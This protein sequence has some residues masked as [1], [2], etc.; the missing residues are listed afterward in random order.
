MG[1]GGVM[2]D[3][4]GFGVGSYGGGSGGYFKTNPNAFKVGGMQ[5]NADP[6]MGNPQQVQNGFQG[7]PAGL[8]GGL[9]DFG[10]GTL[11]NQLFG[12]RGGPMATLGQYG[13]KQALGGAGM[14]ALG[15]AIPGV[16]Q[17]QMI[18]ALLPAALGGLSSLGKSLGIGRKSG[19]SQ[20]EL[21]MGEAKG[22]MMNM[23]GSYG[24][25][26]GTGRSMLDKYNPMLED[27]IGKLQDLANRGLSTEFNTRQMAGAASQTE[28]ARR[29]AE[30]RMK[31]TSGMIG[32]GQ[33]LSGFGGINQAAVGGMAQGA[34]NAAMNNMNQQPGYINQLSGMI[35]NQINR[36]QGLFDQG[37]QNMFQLDQN[38]YNLNAQ[39]KARADQLSQAN[40]DR[41]AAAIGG[42]AQMGMSYLGD[43][44]NERQMDRLMK[45]YGM[46]DEA[47]AM[48]YNGMNIRDL[49]AQRA[50]GNPGGMAPQT[51]IPGQ[52]PGVGVRQFGY[53]DGS[54]M[55]E[56]GPSPALPR[57]GGPRMGNMNP[58]SMAYGGNDFPNNQFRLPVSGFR[59]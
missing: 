13:L 39:E 1:K 14:K 9:R 41:E 35:G 32:G 28:A 53:S 31:A 21:A 8:M 30:A 17:A 11:T 58:A 33:A 20:Q 49:M 26:M 25:D 56:V 57:Y 3:G 40:R 7:L 46:G 44:A 43:Q 34:Y 27:Q 55:G 45:M 23:R 52:M 22:N 38:M 47:Q 24:A 19:P 29:A 54:G 37:R 16:G 36:G 12:S 42:I 15:M 50:A 5:A 6:M 18:G 10:I 51:Q 2:S 48:P 59:L 4:P